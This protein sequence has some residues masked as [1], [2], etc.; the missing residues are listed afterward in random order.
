MQRLGQGRHPLSLP[1][2]G[3]GADLMER[4]LQEKGC[5]TAVR[6]S[7][8]R[9]SRALPGCIPLKW[10]AGGQSDSCNVTRLVRPHKT[11][12][13]FVPSPIWNACAELTVTEMRHKNVRICPGF[14]CTVT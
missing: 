4:V 10:G 12:L 13:S 14:A 8:A 6:E 11:N 5:H 2:S 3:V 1:A 7:S 9:I